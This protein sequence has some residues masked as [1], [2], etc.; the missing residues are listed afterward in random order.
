MNTLYISMNQREKLLGW[1]WLI[2]CAFVMPPLFNLWPG[3]LSFC[4]EAAIGFAGVMLIFH[5]FFL[6]SMHV[7]HTTFTQILLKAS[8]G[9]VISFVANIAMNDLFFFY[10]PK[11][12]SYTDY[13]P[14][15][16]NVNEAAFTE[17]VQHDLLL[18]APAFVILI[19]AAEEI[20]FRGLLFGSLFR[21]NRLLA[22]VISTGLF[23]FLPAL[24]LIGHYPADYI[25][26]NVLQYVPLGL[27]LGWVYTCTETI[28]T[29]I[30]LRML[31]HTLAICS[32]R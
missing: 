31:L 16:F 24:G 2:C 6:A 12:F 27:I 28:I 22:Y 11:Y 15:Y 1:P 18:T 20:L 29:P 10:L 9:L 23:A 25:V 30:V 8:L 19:P 4:L 21:R 3:A 7:P 5:R 26:L 32:M 13:G 17:L 14:M